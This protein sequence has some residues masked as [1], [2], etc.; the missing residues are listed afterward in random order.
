MKNVVLTF[1]ALVGLMLT[2]SSLCAQATREYY[3]KNYWTNTY[4]F[5][6]QDFGCG[7]ES[8][9][10]DDNNWVFVPISGQKNTYQ[11]KHKQSGNSL[12]L[13]VGGLLNFA[14][15]QNSSLGVQ[16]ILE[17]MPTVGENVYRIKNRWKPTMYLN[18]EK[19]SKTDGIE[20]TVSNPNFHSSWWY[21]EG[22]E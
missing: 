1:V 19:V 7:G 9:N 5:G 2:T 18:N 20:C 4:L 12:Y 6:G 21:L 8:A 14:K 3:V 15:V 16:W 13:N 22:D 10:M 17:P 11:I